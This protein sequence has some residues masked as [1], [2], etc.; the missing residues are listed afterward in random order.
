MS[1]ENSFVQRVIIDQISQI[2]F[3]L[4]DPANALCVCLIL[5]TVQ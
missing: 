3:T 1:R 5:R 4:V 2:R